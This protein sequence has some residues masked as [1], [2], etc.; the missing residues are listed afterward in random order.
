MNALALAALLLGAPPDSEYIDP[1]FGPKL[2]WTIPAAGGKVPPAQ[3]VAISPDGTLVAGSFYRSETR[4]DELVIYDRK[5]GAEVHRK[6]CPREYPSVGTLS[7]SRDN[8]HIAIRVYQVE[9]DFDR[10]RESLVLEDLKEKASVKVWKDRNGVLSPTADILYLSTGTHIEFLGLPDLKPVKKVA[11]ADVD[12]LGVSADGRTLV[13][14]HR[15]KTKDGSP[16]RWDNLAVIDA[17]S[18]AV[19]VRHEGFDEGTYSKLAV[20]PD[21]KRIAVCSK[22]GEASV[23][24]AIKEEKP[25]RIRVETPYRLAALW[26]GNDTLGL[27]LPEREGSRWDPKKRD[28]SGEGQTYTD[29]YL[30][31]LSKPEPEAVRWRFENAPAERS[32]AGRFALSGDRRILVAACNGMSVID[33]D[34]RKVERTFTGTLAQPKKK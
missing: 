6:A 32:N 9:T 24:S 16:L 4:C 20:S 13:A 3:L 21:G 11:V 7:F 2:K 19:T 31:D 17:A 26:L 23:W 14:A 28:Y 1:T 18:G 5:T 12:R 30:C 27:F 8:R 34:A 22:R 25:Q 10:F 29:M 15:T 33:L